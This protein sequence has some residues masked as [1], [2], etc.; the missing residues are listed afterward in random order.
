L[1]GRREATV[2]SPS[3]GNAAFLPIKLKAYV[4]DQNVSGNFGY[5]RRIFMDGHLLR[6]M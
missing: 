4:K 3:G 1:T 5:I 6:V 2:I